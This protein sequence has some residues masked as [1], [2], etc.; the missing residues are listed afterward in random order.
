MF[1]N[2]SIRLTELVGEV[3]KEMKTFQ[4]FTFPTEISSG[5]IG[6]IKHNVSHFIQVQCAVA[7]SFGNN[8]IIIFLIIL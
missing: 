7:K 3:I 5:E 1:A 4:K 6:S 2:K 8:L